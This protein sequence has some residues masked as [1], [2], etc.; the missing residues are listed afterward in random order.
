[1]VTG[2]GGA[3]CYLFQ[4]GSSFQSSTQQ[5]IEPGQ[6]FQQTVGKARIEVWVPL[7]QMTEKSNRSDVRFVYG[8]WWLNFEERAG[9]EDLW[10]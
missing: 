9:C 4:S 6:L 3:F 8:G 5:G 1:V 7:S 10:C 2:V